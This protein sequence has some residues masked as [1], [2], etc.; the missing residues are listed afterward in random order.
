MLPQT[1]RRRGAR[2]SASGASGG[3]QTPIRS[4]RQGADAVRSRRQGA[5]APRSPL[6]EKTLKRAGADHLTA[7][8]GGER[9]P[10]PGLRGA[11]VAREIKRVVVRGPDREPIGGEGP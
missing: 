5:D 3:R 9:L 10:D 8:A 7:G 2:A 6:E 11:V 1:P 4:R